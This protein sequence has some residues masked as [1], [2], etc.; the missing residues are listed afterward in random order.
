LPEY[1]LESPV[2][3]RDDWGAVWLVGYGLGRKLG[4]RSWGEYVSVL[5][6]P[7]FFEG[8][9]RLQRLRKGSDVQEELARR[10]TVIQE[11]AYSLGEYGMSAA[12]RLSA[13]PPGTEFTKYTVRA[14]YI[15]LAVVEDRPSIGHDAAVEQARQDLLFVPQSQLAG[16][17]ETTVAGDPAV[18]AAG[19]VTGP[20]G[21]V[22]ERRAVVI[23]PKDRSVVGRLILHT[24]FSDTAGQ[25]DEVLADLLAD[26]TITEDEAENVT[27]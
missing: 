19:T 3:A 24:D 25:I 8:S 7:E 9:G 21:F 26:A 12:V 15:A 23:Y 20:D 11:H 27:L 2:L 17:S 1:S 13:V 22:A 16:V 10:Y 4:E 6:Y 5:K 18:V 14:E